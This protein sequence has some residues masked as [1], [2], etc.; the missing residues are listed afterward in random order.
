MRLFV[1]PEFL[2]SPSIDF[3]DDIHV[4][5]GRINVLRFEPIKI[6]WPPYNVRD[7]WFAV[8]PGQTGR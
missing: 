1:R 4:G 3:S 2:V 8:A 6:V 5:H 7:H